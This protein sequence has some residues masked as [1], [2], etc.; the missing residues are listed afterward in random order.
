MKVNAIKVQQ[1]L[2]DF[3]ITKIKAGDLLNIAYTEEFRYKKDGTQEGTQRPT[4]EK[5]LKEISNYIRSEEM[6]FPS[7]ILIALNKDTLFDAMSNEDEENLFGIHCVKDDIYELIIPD[8]KKCAL[9]IDGQHR[10]KAFK[11]VDSALQN[12]E[13]VCSVFFDLPN[14]YQAYLFATINGNQKKVDK[15]L[16]LEFFGYNVEEEPHEQWTPEKLAVYLTR[17]LNFKNDSPLFHQLKLAASYD[18]S[19]NER[20]LA[21]TAAMAEGILSL[22]SSNPKRDRDII[23]ATKNSFFTRKNRNIVAEIKDLSPLRDLFIKCLDDK[24]YDILANF[25]TVVN[26]LIWDKANPNAVIKKTIGIL[27]LFD[28]LKNI[29][30]R[31]DSDI[32]LLSKDNFIN[33][34]ASFS[35]VNFSDNFF[36][37]S[38]LGQGRI[39]RIIKYLSKISAY[40]S[41]KEDDVE[42]L[43]NSWNVQAILLGYVYKTA[44]NY[45]IIFCENYQ[46]EINSVLSN[47]QSFIRDM[48]N[49]TS[50]IIKSLF[51]LAN[52]DSIVIEIFNNQFNDEKSFYDMLYHYTNNGCIERECISGFLYAIKEKYGEEFAKIFPEYKNH[53]C[54]LYYISPDFC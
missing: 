40:E 36:S 25:F 27:A 41:L 49:V 5:R 42:F 9:I 6:C 52:K 14:P 47:N 21:S 38:G 8:S 48:D 33:Y 4:D 20:K 31:N 3:Y 15:S 32:S 23:S 11:Y 13:L 30:K 39:K 37:T 43:Q 44:Y 7:S 2:G 19:E 28:L 34:I 18:D 35:F 26:K 54:S 46:E 24:L 17:K 12:I 10:L 1:P 51:M 45:G 16:A 29:I 53:E 22:I 50:D